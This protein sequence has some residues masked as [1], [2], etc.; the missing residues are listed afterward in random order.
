[1]RE[2]QLRSELEAALATARESEAIRRDMLGVLGHEM[3]TPVLSA[4]A[5]L[6]LVPA[7][8]RTRDTNHYLVRAE[9]GLKALECL[10][11]DLLDVSLLN[12]GEFRLEAEPFD[13][14]ELLSDTV[15]IMAPVAE[16]NKLDLRSDWS[17]SDI[18]VVG[19]SNRI[20]QI[21][22]NLLSNAIKYTR[23]GHIILKSRCN[24][25]PEGDCQIVICVKDT[26]LGIPEEKVNDVFQPFNRLSQ[27]HR[28]GIS[29][30]GLGLAIT[31]RL[32]E[33]MGGTISVQSTVGKGSSFCLEIAL[34][35]ALQP[36]NEN[37]AG[38]HVASGADL[39]GIS[40]MVVEDHPLQSA[41]L[42]RM[43]SELQASVVIA[44]S[45]QEALAAIKVSQFDVVLI[46]LGLPDM[47]GEELVRQLKNEDPTSVNI[48]LSANPGLLT[49]QQQALFDVVKGKTADKSLIKAM[50]LDALRQC[51]H[52]KKEYKLTASGLQGTD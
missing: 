10:I 12:A 11:Q 31:K 5:A 38:F 26:G 21:L 8:L 39:D 47:T 52:E 40:I 14:T 9:K 27:S 49:E 1:M 20:R 25:G 18:R 45:G 48:A 13:L 41:L 46:D 6:Q 7:D 15:D 43:L 17:N 33:A 28:Q 32:A 19:D 24:I 16:C 23:E 42:S 37:A 34:P 44:T 29:G 22:I 30:L 3:R 2:C 51:T 50:V 36:L 35:R 4:L